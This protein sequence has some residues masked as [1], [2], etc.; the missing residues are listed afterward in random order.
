M[1]E[2]NWAVFELAEAGDSES[3]TQKIVDDLVRRIPGIEVFC[4]AFDYSFGGRR[5]KISF[6]PGYVFARLPVGAE[7]KLLLSLEESPF[8]RSALSESC[9]GSGDP[10]I[11]LVSDKEV[12]RLRVKFEEN[13]RGKFKDGATVRI[14]EGDLD[15]KEGVVVSID[16]DIVNVWVTQGQYGRVEEIPI[17]F[18]EPCGPLPT[19]KI[20]DPVTSGAAISMLVDTGLI[21]KTARSMLYHGARGNESRASA[22]RQKNATLKTWTFSKSWVESIVARRFR[23]LD[24]KKKA[25]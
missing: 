8:I 22:D 7:A 4:P 17:Y 23:K 19:P 18:V 24:N 12:L 9:G 14:T 15:G 1:Y 6:L 5:R 11:D 25:E 13:L 3:D 2:R 21:P 16:A 10:K 20:P